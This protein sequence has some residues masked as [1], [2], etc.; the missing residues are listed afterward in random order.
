MKKIFFA[1]SLL[2]IGSAT[3]AQNPQYENTMKGFIMKTGSATSP[4]AFQVVANGF[5]RIAA[6][7]KAEWLPHYYAAYNYA[8]QAMMTTDKAKVDGIVDQA[9]AHLTTA[10]ELAPNNDE[11]LCLNALCKSARIGVD[12]M[13]RGM[14]MGME[15]AKY[16]EQAKKINEANPRIYFL[17]AQSVF[18]TPEAFGGGKAKAKPM[19]EK[20]V[21][22][23]GT[24]K[25]SSELMPNWG[26]AQAKTMLEECSK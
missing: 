26:A 10:S 18:Y 5:E 14:K 4:E 15:S 16:L 24:F 20:A 23:Y 17:Q 9:E 13:S 11:I 6:T 19:F 2:L 21:M 22:T 25:P 12:P 8:M 7:E 3:F 1:L